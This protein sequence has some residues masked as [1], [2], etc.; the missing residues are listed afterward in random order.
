M[1]V[2]ETMARKFWPNGDALGHSITMGVRPGISDTDV[3][4]EIVGIVGDVHDFG[5]DIEPTPTVYVLMDIPGSSYM[6][7]VVRTAGDPAALVQ[8]ARATVAALDADMPLADPAPMEAVLATSLEQRRFYMLLLSIFAAVA[9]LLAGIGLYGVISY[10]VGQRTQEIGVRMA[11]GATRRQVLGMILSE[12]LRLA[13]TGIAA[14][15]LGALALSRLLKGMLVG[16]STTDAGVF[17]AAALGIGVIAL[18]A[19]YVPARRATTVDPVVALRY[20]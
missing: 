20:E 12:S 13:G 17:A 10:S 18:V 11:L 15:I 7:I 6:N 8:S 14:G 3:G 5:L 2:S 19:C 16:V 4:G 1:L 9:L